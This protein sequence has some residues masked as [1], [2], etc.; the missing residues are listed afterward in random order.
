MPFVY[1]KPGV[2]RNGTT[3]LSAAIHEACI[4]W[5][6]ENCHFGKGI[7]LVREMS[8]L[9]PHKSLGEGAD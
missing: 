4:G 6:H 2:R 7:F 8:N 5:L 9:F 3:A 1:I